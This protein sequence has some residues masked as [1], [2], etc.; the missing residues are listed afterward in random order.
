MVPLSSIKPESSIEFL[1]LL[2]LLLGLL[3]GVGNDD[4]GGVGL[5]GVND[6]LGG[7]DSDD[8]GG[9]GLDSFDL[10]G[11]GSHG[12][13]NESGEGGEDDLAH[14][15]VLRVILGD[16]PVTGVKRNSNSRFVVPL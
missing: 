16:A 12:S 10:F 14:F 7:V 2:S 5:G 9:V 11:L 6:G 1:L 15:V 13:N 8:L 3:G 4:L